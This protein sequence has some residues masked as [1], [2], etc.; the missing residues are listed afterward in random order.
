MDL[1]ANLETYQVG[2]HFEALVEGVLVAP[3]DSRYSH[4]GFNPISAQECPGLFAVVYL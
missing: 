3:L 4:V 1:D 2:A